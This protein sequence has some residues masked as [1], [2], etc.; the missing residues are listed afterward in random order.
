MQQKLH[1]MQEDPG[2][3][4]EREDRHSTKKQFLE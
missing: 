4:G 1:Y 3:R 2:L